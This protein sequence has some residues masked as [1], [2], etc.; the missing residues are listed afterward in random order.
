MTQSI[1]GITSNFPRV[2]IE[3]Q[4]GRHGA[5]AR[6]Q[7]RAT[8]AAEPDSTLELSQEVTFV[9]LLCC[10]TPEQYAEQALWMP[11]R[12]AT[13][14]KLRGYRRARSL[15]VLHGWQWPA[16]LGGLWANLVE[17]RISRTPC[18]NLSTQNLPPLLEILFL[19]HVPKSDQSCYEPNKPL[20]ALS[21]AIPSRLRAVSI[22]MQT[23]WFSLDDNLAPLRQQTALTA[24]SVVTFSMQPF[25]STLHCSPEFFNAPIANSLRSLKLSTSPTLGVCLAPLNKLEAI[26]FSLSG[27]HYTLDNVLNHITAWST[28]QKI[29]A[30]LPQNKWPYEA[31]TVQIES[32][33]DVSYAPRSVERN[34]QKMARVLA[35]L[36]VSADQATAVFRQAA[37]LT[38]APEAVPLDDLREWLRPQ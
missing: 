31:R 38:C 14:N 6:L 15:Y 25:R 4:F 32:K 28:L 8:K 11:D 16:T 20:F 26:D 9:R 18:H 13:L 5:A 37:R 10:D 21:G 1:D 35:R 12:V 7:L 30:T 33:R 34:A 29:S 27:A 22:S 19:D 17:V 3:R 23:G 2:R 36:G 24:L